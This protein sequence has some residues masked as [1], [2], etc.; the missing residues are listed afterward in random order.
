[1]KKLTN[2]LAELM[3]LWWGISAW[4]HLSH[5]DRNEGRFVASALKAEKL[6]AHSEEDS[7]R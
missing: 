3:H 7:H 5:S 6:K 1:M 4:K 2:A